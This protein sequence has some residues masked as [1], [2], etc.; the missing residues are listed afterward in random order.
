MPRVRAATATL[1]HC[2]F[3]AILM[4]G[5]YALINALLFALAPLTTGWPTWAVTALAVPPMVLGMV[6]LVIPLA[7]RSGR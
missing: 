2:R 7:R 5:A 6:H 3:L 4:F 1:A